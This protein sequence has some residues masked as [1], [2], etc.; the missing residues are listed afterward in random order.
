MQNQIIV[1]AER[2]ETRVALLERSQFLEFH[3]ER[4]ATKDVVGNVVKARVSRVL[5]GM[6][7]AFVDIGLEKAGFLYVGDYFDQTTRGGGR[8]GGRGRDRQ[9]PPPIDTVLSEGQEI[10]VQIAKEPIGT[11]GARIT[12][13]VSI[14]GR[15]LVLTP[16]SPRVGVSRR[17]DS[18]RE[19]RRLREIVERL[20]PR[21]LGF[22]IRTAGDGLKE[23][24]LEADINYLTTVWSE[25]QEKKGDAS[26]PS[27]LYSEPDL[28]QRVLR[29]FANSDTKSIVI[30]D[31]QVY[32][33]LLEFSKRFVSDPQPVIEHYQ[34]KAPIFDH[35]DLESQIHA[36]LER[37]VPLKSGG[38]LVIDQSEAL[39]AIDVNSGRYVG[40]RDLEETVF[41]TNLEAVK[42]VVHQLRFRNIGGLIIIDLIDM[43]SRNNREKVYRA[44]QDAARQDKAKT[45]VLKISE[46]GLV[47]MTRKRTR[48]NLVQALCEPC[49]SCE[50]RGYVLSSESVGFKVMREIR[51]D[52]HAFCGRQIAVTVSPQVAHQLL[53]PEAEPLA[54]L[55]AELGRELEVRARPGLH[56]E[57]FE[58]STLDQGP[59]VEIAL[60]WLQEPKPDKD[61][62]EQ[63]LEPQEAT[64]PSEP[65]TE[66]EPVEPEASRSEDGPGALEEEAAVA[67]EAPTGLEPADPG[68][69][70]SGD[71]PGALGG[72]ETPAE[73][74]PAQ[75]APE[76]P[77]E[78]A[79]TLDEPLD[80]RILPG[81][82][83]EPASEDS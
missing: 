59:P 62:A 68:A 23:S 83:A 10:V 74:V 50:G 35:F 14:A 3:I 48:E 49:A 12:S 20:R 57:Q 45:N 11:K 30:D 31:K 55:S 34:G 72:Q 28:P 64:A 67:G 46:L 24:D 56:Q 77:A 42:E 2:G 70:P 44:L 39:T 79:Q 7:A 16:W 9:P 19:R 81:S 51:K 36:N 52:M 25:I 38:S 32:E 21:D 54:R 17:I 6:Q 53:G 58:I 18:D 78:E 65:P 61:E 76:P 60:D 82:R 27:V 73:P 15:H 40:K 13:H 26:A 80:S 37:K 69:A 43:E 29:D 66:L 71:G 41:R 75:A 47:E 22:I 4:A 5:P 33:D 63:E 1:N 8:S